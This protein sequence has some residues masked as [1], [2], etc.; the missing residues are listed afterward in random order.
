MSDFYRSQWP[1]G[2][3]CRSAAAWL[4]GS[5]VRIHSIS[6]VVAAKNVVIN[7]F[8]TSPTLYTSDAE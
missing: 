5:R 6:I 8:P 3:R 2:L 1:R 4:L 7:F